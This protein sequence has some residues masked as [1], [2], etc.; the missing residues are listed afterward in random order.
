M[1]NAF[2]WMIA[3]VVVF[4][5][6][7]VFVLQLDYDFAHSPFYRFVVLNAAPS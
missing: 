3:M 6:M 7:A 2:I 4:A 5:C 1:K